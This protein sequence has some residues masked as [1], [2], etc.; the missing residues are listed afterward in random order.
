[1]KKILISFIPLIF[2]RKKFHVK[3]SLAIIPTPNNSQTIVR[4]IVKICFWAICE[5]NFTISLKKLG[6]YIKKIRV[7]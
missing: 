4:N 7:R 1:M 3:N 5:V 2:K 6:V